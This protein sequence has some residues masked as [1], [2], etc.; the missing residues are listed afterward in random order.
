MP[1]SRAG[2]LTAV[3]NAWDEVMVNVS[4]GCLRQLSCQYLM[5][6]MSRSMKWGRRCS[7]RLPECNCENM[8][9][10]RKRKFQSKEVWEKFSF[11]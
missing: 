6:I 10:D 4:V 3:I 7:C 2:K 5:V 8:K 11:M 1:Q 9:T